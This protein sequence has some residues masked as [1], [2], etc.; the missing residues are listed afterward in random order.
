MKYTSIKNPIWSNLNKTD[1]DCLIK[2]D[3]L[4][5]EVPFTASMNDICAHGRDIFNEI[6]SG[7]FGVIS[8]YIP[9]PPPSLEELAQEIRNKRDFLLKESDWTQLSDVPKETKEIWADYRQA[10]RDITEQNDFPT[11]VEF[12]VKPN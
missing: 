5:E 12:P 2:F 6:T 4:D 9:P 1:I 7:K 3:H 8:D 11:A 10:L